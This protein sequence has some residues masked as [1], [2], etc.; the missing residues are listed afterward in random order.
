MALPKEAQEGPH[1]IAAPP[2]LTRPPPCM[3]A[4]SNK[5]G[6][7][8]AQ[9]CCQCHQLCVFFFL[10]AH[11]WV[12]WGWGKPPQA[13]SPPC[14]LLLPFTG[15][16]RRGCTLLHTL[17][18][19]LHG[20][21]RGVVPT[22]GGHHGC[23]GATPHH[24]TSVGGIWCPLV[25]PMAHKPFL[26]LTPLHTTHTTGCLGLHSTPHKGLGG[27]HVAPQP[28]HRVCG[29]WGCMGGHQLGPTHIVRHPFANSSEFR[30]V[31][32]RGLNHP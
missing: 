8:L 26:L 5:E 31:T 6:R 22:Q 12:W 28:P 14:A 19:G 1:C 7:L 4:Y 16:Y 10:W 11:V 23:H 9:Q 21:G 29:C 3:Q 18:Q 13:S 15:G 27:G 17:G 32:V 25:P 30:T 20:G 24:Q 2:Q